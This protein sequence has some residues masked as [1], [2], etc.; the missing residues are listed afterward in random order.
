MNTKQCEGCSYWDKYEKL[1]N[2]NSLT[3]YA[4]LRPRKGDKCLARTTEPITKQA[5]RPCVKP[6]LSEL[7]EMRVSW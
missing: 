1:C 5:E 3:G 7:G 4:Q 6:L 2:Y